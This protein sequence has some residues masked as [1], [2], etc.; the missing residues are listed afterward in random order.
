MPRTAG[1]M[2]FA[3]FVE[4]RCSPQLQSQGTAK[5]ACLTVL[6]SMASVVSLWHICPGSIANNVA[7]LLII[8]PLSLLEEMHF[9][10]PKKDVI[11]PHL[12]FLSHINYVIACDNCCEPNLSS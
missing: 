12:P 7:H 6:Y 5:P 10:P 11:F 1:A 3:F 2:I 4:S 9:F 8:I